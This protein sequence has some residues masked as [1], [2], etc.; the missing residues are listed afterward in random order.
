MEAKR[1]SVVEYNQLKATGMMFEFYPQL[2]GDYARDVRA[3]LI[4]NP[5]LEDS[6]KSLVNE[7]KVQGKR[8]FNGKSIIGETVINESHLVDTNTTMESNFHEI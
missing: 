6:T 3:G 2:T 1:M 5:L 8:T 4:I 7:Q